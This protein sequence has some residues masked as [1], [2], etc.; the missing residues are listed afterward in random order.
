MKREEEKMKRKS[1]GGKRVPFS[2][3]SPLIPDDLF[4]LRAPAELLVSLFSGLFVSIDPSMGSEG[5]FNR[6]LFSLSPV[7]SK[8]HRVSPVETPPDLP[9][10]ANSTSQR[11]STSSFPY[12]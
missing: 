9:A 3:L 1:R 8:T 5:G 12:R 10:L 2:W 4:F 6:S 11:L 7:E